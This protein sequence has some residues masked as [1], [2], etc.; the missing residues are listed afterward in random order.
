ML[1]YRQAVLLVA[2]AAPLLVAASSGSAPPPTVAVP[3]PSELALQWY[4]TG[5]VVWIAG[6]VWGIAAPGLIFA[7]GLSARLRDAARRIGSRFFFTVAS[8]G[9]LF[10]VVAFAL[11][12]PLSVYVSFLRPHAYGLSNQSL[13]KWF[14]DEGT[15]LAVSSVV[16][17]ATLWVPYVLVRWSPRRWWLWTSGLCLP[18]VLF[19]TL[20]QPVWVAPLYNDFGPMKDRALEQRILGLAERA[21]IEGGRVYEV[22]KSVDTKMVNAYVNGL[23][24]TKRIVL[25]D[26]LLAKL[27][28]E[29]VL[30]VMGHEMGHYVL[31]H[32]LL[33][34]LGASL[35]ILVLLYAVHRTAPALLLRLAPWSGVR[36]LGDVASLPLVLVLIQLYGLVLSPVGL[37]LSRTLEHDAD[38]FAL[39]ITQDNHAMAT[40]FAKLQTENL[41]NPW[42][43]SWVVWLR[44]THP[45]LGERIGFAN[46]Y[47]PWASG[48]PLRYADHFRRSDGDLT[49]P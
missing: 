26:T 49:P 12:L 40:A 15:S 5:L 2:L 4:R 18:F 16:L 3:E 36:E 47:R 20:V 7:T 48:A 41:G 46:D 17:V 8:Y 27:E 42:P 39:E 35:G 29:E 25:W 33:S 38:R 30:A 34:A 28:P 9:L 10:G 19:V 6:I 43:D 45:P 21:G 22:A 44:Y 24:A 13:V 11:D 14:S 31:N 1:G 37:A 23:G 32:V